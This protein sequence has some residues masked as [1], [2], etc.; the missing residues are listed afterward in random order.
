M[1][2]DKKADAKSIMKILMLS[3]S[4]G[5]Y[6]KVEIS[7]D[8]QDANKFDLEAAK[9]VVTN[10]KTLMNSLPEQFDKFYV[11]VIAKYSNKIKQT[12]ENKYHAKCHNAVA[13]LGVHFCFCSMP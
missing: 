11:D 6:I 1:A 12:I 7:G 3:A 2:D 5:T 13:V 8:N 9:S 10:V 4:E